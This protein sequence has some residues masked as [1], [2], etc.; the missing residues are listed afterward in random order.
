VA[1]RIRGQLVERQDDALHGLGVVDV[2]GAPRDG[3]GTPGDEATR[4]TAHRRQLEMAG[5]PPAVAV[6]R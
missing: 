1:Q 6:G 5:Q 2:P 4:S 3:G